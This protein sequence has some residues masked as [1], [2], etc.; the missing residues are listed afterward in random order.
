MAIWCSCFINILISLLG[1]L[2]FSSSLIGRSRM[3]PLTPVVIVMRGWSLP[4]SCDS[5]ASG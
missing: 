4:H 3:A 5:Q 1:I 2:R